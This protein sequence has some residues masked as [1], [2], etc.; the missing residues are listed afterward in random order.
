MKNISVEK[1][2]KEIIELKKYWFKSHL[3]KNGITGNIISEAFNSLCLDLTII[4]L[5]NLDFHDALIEVF[6]LIRSYDSAGDSLEGNFLFDS[7][8]EE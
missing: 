8:W 4:E 6:K 2:E 1:I 5:A 3:E 7:K